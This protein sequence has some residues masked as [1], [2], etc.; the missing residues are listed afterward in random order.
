VPGIFGAHELFHV[1]VMA[2]S[3]THFSFM[4]RYVVPYKRRRSARPTMT[5]PA[6]QPTG[7]VLPDASG[8]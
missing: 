1:F 7:A 2:G 6:P 4:L 3:L 5:M 8:V